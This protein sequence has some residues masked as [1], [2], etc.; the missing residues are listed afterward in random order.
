MTREMPR[1]ADSEEPNRNGKT[2]AEFFSLDLSQGGFVLS[3]DPGHPRPTHDSSD[4]TFG[5]TARRV[6]SLVCGAREATSVDVSRRGRTETS[7]RAAC[8]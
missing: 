3:S 8:A 1:L 5:G 2:A 7:A 4:D 6:R